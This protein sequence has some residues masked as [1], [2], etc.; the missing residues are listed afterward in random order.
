MPIK[1]QKRDPCNDEIVLKLYGTYVNFL[2]VVL[3][4]S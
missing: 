4:Y 2:I 3:Y 1:G